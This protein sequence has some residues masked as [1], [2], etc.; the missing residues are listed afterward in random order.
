[1]ISAG[2]VMAAMTR[3]LPPQR[4]QVLMSIENTRRLSKTPMQAWAMSAEHD[5]AYGRK[6]AVELCCSQAHRREIFQREPF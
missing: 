4:A 3:T 6:E 5:A 1:M 2:C